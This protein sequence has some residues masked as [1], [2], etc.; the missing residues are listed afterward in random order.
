[1]VYFSFSNLFVVLCG[2]V[3]SVVDLLCCIG[4][5]VLIW[6]YVVFVLY[7]LFGRVV[8]LLTLGFC[9]WHYVV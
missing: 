1:M 8:L 6:I 7:V 2:V 5:F 9:L 4:C 3:C